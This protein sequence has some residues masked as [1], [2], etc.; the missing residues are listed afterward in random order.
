MGVID[1]GRVPIEGKIIH[2]LELRNEKHCY[3]YL[4]IGLTPK[5]LGYDRK[6]YDE[7]PEFSKHSMY[8]F[9][10]VSAALRDYG[11]I[12]HS[13]ETG[14]GMDISSIVGGRP[15]WISTAISSYLLRIKIEFELHFGS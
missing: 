11:N 14:Y 6:R 15:R 4:A 9:L 13:E 2:T 3:G 5:Y 1:F 7:L 12:N 8:F 10:N